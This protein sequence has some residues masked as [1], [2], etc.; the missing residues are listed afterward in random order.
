M[1]P[2]IVKRSPELLLALSSRIRHLLFAVPAGINPVGYSVIGFARL[3]AA[4]CVCYALG[5]G[6][7]NRG[8]RMGG[9]PV[10]GPD[11]GDVPL[12][13]ARRRPIRAAP[14]GPDAGQQHRVRARRLP[15]HAPGV[16]AAC[17]SIGIAVRL[18]WVWVAAKQFED[19]LKVPST[20][21]SSYQWWLVGGFFAVTFLQSVAARRRLAGAAVLA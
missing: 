9:A 4:G 8:M 7:G 10:R 13:A 14:R 17:L 15:P 18:V 3:F 2:T 12:D 1:A 16:F 20:G 6:Y 19:Q 21:S 5:H 11:A